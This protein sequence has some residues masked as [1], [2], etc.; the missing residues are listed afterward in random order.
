MRMHLQDISDVVYVT[1][2]LFDPSR[3]TEI[4]Q[5]IHQVKPRT[6]TRPRTPIRSR[7][8]TPTLTPTPTPT[9]TLTLSNQVNALLR[10]C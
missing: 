8:P 6:L 10:G 3:T 9:P 7:T 2:E 5:Q 4:A 1:P